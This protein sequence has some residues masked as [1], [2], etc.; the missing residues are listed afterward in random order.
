VSLRADGEWKVHGG[1]RGGVLSTSTWGTEQAP[2]VFLAEHLL[3]QRAI[4]VHKKV[5]KA[6]VLD[7]E[8]TE[9]AQSKAEELNE[10]FGEWIWED[11]DRAEKIVRRYNDT[12]NSIVLRSYD[13]VELSLPGLNRNI[14]LHW[15]Q[16]AAVA[17]MIAEP[18][19]GLFH[20]MGA[21]KTLEQI[22][23]MMEL[24]RL[25]LIN[26]PVMCVKNHMLEQ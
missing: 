17:R 13:D 21:G 12:F 5:D 7:E 1:P 26:K 3:N 19:V 15:W 24:R 16:K 20:D 18:A 14:R 23:G 25:G 10:R 2:A 6:T 9:A 11:L 22:I 4:K 8:A